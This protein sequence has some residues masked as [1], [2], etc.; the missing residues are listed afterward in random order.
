M[1]EPIPDAE[2]VEA[3]EM[4]QPA[5]GPLD[6]FADVPTFPAPR[7][8]STRKGMVQRNGVSPQMGR[9][10]VAMYHLTN[11]GQREI[12]P[13]AIA[14]IVSV[15][16]GRQVSGMLSGAIKLGYVQKGKVGDNGRGSYRLTASGERAV[17]G[18]G[19]WPWDV[20]ELGY[21]PWL[22]IEPGS[23]SRTRRHG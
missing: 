19:T 17:S 2:S 15:V 6:V 21:P 13:S 23:G 12:F 10:L 5:L 18:L 4:E 8:F 7:Q 22:T 9:V 16:D 20:R 1:M 11:N 14:E 3:S